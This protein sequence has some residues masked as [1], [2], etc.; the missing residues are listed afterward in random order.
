MSNDQERKENLFKFWCAAKGLRVNNCNLV[1]S[2]DKFGVSLSQCRDL[3]AD[4][5]VSVG[6]IDSAKEIIREA[7]NY[8]RHRMY[9]IVMTSIYLID[10]LENYYSQEELVDFTPL[11][12]LADT[13]SGRMLRQQSVA[14]HQA[15]VAAGGGVAQAVQSSEP[16]ESSYKEVTDS[17]AVVLSIPL[18]PKCVQDLKELVLGV[19]DTR[20]KGY[21]K[22]STTIKV[23]EGGDQTSTIEG[24]RDAIEK[25]W[26][27]VVMPKVK[28]SIAKYVER[29]CPDKDW[30]K[31]NEELLTKACNTYFRARVEEGLKV[32][33]QPQVG[34][35]AAG[36]AT[37]LASLASEAELTNASSATST[38]YN[39]A[40]TY[41]E[42]GSE[43][44][45]E[46]DLEKSTKHTKKRGKKRA[47]R[48]VAAEEETLPNEHAKKAQESSPLDSF[49]F[50]M[51][52][53]R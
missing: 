33:F 7:L 19:L 13:P 25:S 36:A 53:T 46:E 50:A 52:K 1:I 8:T 32:E 14:A 41:S 45:S 44:D 12:E 22:V 29:S 21:S 24:V 48:E 49:E 2:E 47:V 31:K 3:D 5:V 34:A 23:P 42:E 10:Q 9:P 6:G 40:A 18:S 17:G 11:K 26:F 39:S 28:E 30:Y 51:C 27:P 20:C 15:Q 4:S 43:E 38:R 37:P 16:A 35:A